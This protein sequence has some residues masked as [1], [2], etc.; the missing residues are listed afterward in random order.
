MPPPHWIRVDI[1]RGIERGGGVL[2]GPPFLVLFLGHI[3]FV[4]CRA[5]SLALVVTLLIKL[6][7]V[8]ILVSPSNKVEGGEAKIFRN[9]AQ[10]LAIGRGITKG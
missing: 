3:P 4:L 2:L 9:G 1:R 8:V 5:N 6:S 7:T 10:H